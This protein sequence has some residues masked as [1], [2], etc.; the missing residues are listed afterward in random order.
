LRNT[1]ED[2]NTFHSP[3]MSKINTVNV[4]RKILP[5]EIYR[6]NAI[7]IKIPTQLFT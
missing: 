2:R 7:A 4:A 6:F 5:E 3:Q 1:S